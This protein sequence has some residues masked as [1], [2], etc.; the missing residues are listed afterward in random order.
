[1]TSRSAPIAQQT[2][3]SDLDNVLYLSAS[4]DWRHSDLTHYGLTFDFQEA[5]TNNVDDSLELFTYM[6][7]KLSTLWSL[8]P[9]LY[10][11]LSESSPD[12]GRGLQFTYKP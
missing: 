10:F 9:Y 1:M 11:G 8:T 3:G 5:S 6:N 4:I 12:F 7:Y 2:R